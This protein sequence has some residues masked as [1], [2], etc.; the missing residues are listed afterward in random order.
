MA[1]INPTPPEDQSKGIELSPPP[2]TTA[3]KYF[4]ETTP[5]N[6]GP[7]DELMSAAPQL[8]DRPPGQDDKPPADLPTAEG[9]LLP[10]KPSVLKQQST[11]HEHDPNWCISEGEF[12][13]AQHFK[14]CTANNGNL[15]PSA[16]EKS[17]LRGGG[18]YVAWNMK[19]L[20]A[21]VLDVV[22]FSWLKKGRKVG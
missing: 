13:F 22:K 4:P 12:T 3:A 17:N 2:D 8:S 21:C 19:K 20:R 6:E 9:D 11:M 14:H 7:T 16:V 5:S 10:K 18:V 1:T 15:C